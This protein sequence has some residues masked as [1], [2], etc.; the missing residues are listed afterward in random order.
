M[1]TIPRSTILFTIVVLMISL[2]V[3]DWFI[4]HQTRDFIIRGIRED[5]RKKIALARTL[6]NESAF[7]N[8]K[9]ARLKRFADDVKRR[10]GLR[11]TLIDKQGSV[12]ADSEVPLDTVRRVENHLDRLEVQEALRKGSGLAMR[13]SATIQKKLI[14]YCETF[15]SNG[16]V[17]GFIRLAMFSPEFNERISYLRNVIIEVNL[18]LVLF[19]LISALVYGRSMKRRIQKIHGPLAEQKEMS[20][21][22]NLPRQSLEELDLLA[23]DIN[24]LGSKMEI[25]AKTLRTEKEDLQNI[26]N[27]LTEGVA[28]FNDAGHPIIYNRKFLDILDIEENRIIKSPY[29]D[30]LHF[31]PLIQDIETYLSNGQPVKKRLK[32]YGQIFIEYQILPLQKIDRRKWS[33]L[34]TLKDVTHLQRLETIRR[35]FVANVSHEFKT[36]LTSIRGYAETLLSGTAQDSQLMK[37]FLKKIEKQ[38]H[39]LENLVGDLLQLSRVEKKQETEIREMDPFPVIREIAEEFIPVAQ[40]NGLAL[41]LEIQSFEKEA[42]T[43]YA[44][45]NLLHTLLS[46]LMTNAIQYNRTGGKIWVRFYRKADHLCLEV[47]DTGIGVSAAE[48]ERIY[49]RFYRTEISRSRY[50]EGSG[51]GLSI[52]K[53]IVDLLNG[54]TGV[55]SQPEKGS[56]FWVELPLASRDT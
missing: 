32:Y 24:A 4:W 23:S 10:T 30:W 26:F 11:T 51:L 21:F 50:A 7:E 6:V 25:R 16:R 29:Y 43:I 22:Q 38:T 28:A 40:S 5:L 8:R 45:P 44:N 2:S 36:P 42:V 56:L 54:S 39:Y 17:I 18:L 52:V 12:L 15:R 41:E 53:H 37:K 33:F 20:Q 1:K 47:E 14:Y 46:N 9:H 34:V 35:D 13:E 27:S 19:L 3:I 55:K 48:I 31:P 49:E